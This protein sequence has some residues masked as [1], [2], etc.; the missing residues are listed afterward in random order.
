[1]NSTHCKD[2][3]ECASNSTNNCQQLCNN[4]IGSYNCSCS[5]G[6]NLLNATSCIDVDE[7][8]SNTSNNCQQLCNN[9]N[10]SYFCS[11]NSGYTLSQSYLCLDNDECAN[12]SHTCHSNATCSNIPGSYS[13]ACA[14]GFTGNGYNCSGTSIFLQMNLL[15]RFHT[16]SSSIHSSQ[17]VCCTPSV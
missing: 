16:C 2:V 11:C 9:T 15:F 17:K 10:G 3:D 14:S 7:C 5:Q 13:C 12:A 6:F 1:M 4:Q 8:A